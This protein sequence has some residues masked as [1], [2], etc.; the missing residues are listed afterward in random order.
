[1]QHVLELLYKLKIK[2]MISDTLNVKPIFSVATASKFQN[3]ISLIHLEQTVMVLLMV[4][5]MDGVIHVLLMLLLQSGI[6]ISILHKINIWC[7]SISLMLKVHG[8][9]RPK[10]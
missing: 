3:L 7:L 6:E 9:I 5:M 2:V 4:K 1:M 8:Q 10:T